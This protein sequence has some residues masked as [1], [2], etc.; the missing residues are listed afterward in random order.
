[1]EYISVSKT[2]KKWGVSITS[3]RRAISKGLVPGAELID[4]IRHIPEDAENPL[5]KVIAP[6]TG[7]I[8][9]T[10]AAEKWG[11]R[12][13]SVC[14]AAKEGRIPGAELVGG[15]WH[16]PEN[17][18]APTNKKTERLAGYMSLTK[19]AEKWGTTTAVV[20]RAISNDRIPGVELIDGK[21]HIPE[22]AK[23]PIKKAKVPKSGY[24]STK[25][26]A[27]KW[28]FRK[29]SVSNAARGGRIPGAKLIGGEWYIPEDAEKPSGRRKK[30]YNRLQ[31]TTAL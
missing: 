30:E 2:A 23:N 11:I 4:G 17:M 21:W 25:E 5:K 7:Y 18:S 15:R 8:S 16:I 19:T 9:T 13:D 6:K 22:D 12:A 10:E 26:A 29:E 3:V 1:M 14:D 20:R 27:E 28:N 31:R 24:I